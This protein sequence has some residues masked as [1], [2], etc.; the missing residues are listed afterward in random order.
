MRTRLDII[1]RVLLAIVLSG[2]PAPSV[3][4]ATEA[5]QQQEQ[6][7]TA[8]PATPPSQRRTTTHVKINRPAREAAGAPSPTP[9]AQKSHDGE[10]RASASAT[11]TPAAQP[12]HDTAAETEAA[13]KK[14]A[15]EEKEAAAKEAAAR[16]KAEADKKKEADAQAAAEAKRAADAARRTEEERLAGMAALERERAA[17]AS[18]AEAKA[19]AEMEVKVEAERRERAAIEAA[20]RVREEKSAREAAAEK[21]KSDAE[22]AR[23]E[24]IEAAAKE[25]EIILEKE[26]SLTVARLAENEKQQKR[27]SDILA[28]ARTLNFRDP[29]AAVVLVPV[30]AIDYRAP[31][32]DAARRDPSLVR[33]VTVTTGTFCDSEFVGQLITYDLPGTTSTISDILA[34]IRLN[35]GANFIPDTD[36]LETA[37]RLNVTNVPWTVVLRKILKSNDLEASCDAGGIIQIIKRTKLAAMQD[38]ERKSSPLVE[39]FI[40]LRY[41]QISP[42]QISNIAGKSTNPS[43]GAYSTLEEAINK[44]LRGAGDERAQV[45]RVPN[46]NELFV[47]ASNDTL[48]RIKRLIAKA[49]RPSYI[50]SVQALIYTANQNRLKDLGVQSAVTLSN[51]LG[52]T[53]GGFSTL[54]NGGSGSG[55]TSG[56]LNPG[57]IGGIGRG[58]GQPSNAQA[59]IN[60]TVLLGGS[61]LFG[62]AQVAVQL[63]ALQQRGIINIQQRPS[64]L[65]SSGD[66]GVLDVGRNIAVAV[67]ALGT[68]NIATGQLELLNA[69]SSLSI[70]PQV[71]EDENGNPAFVNLDVRLEANDVDTSI[72]TTVAP[73]I[74]RRAI[75]TRFVMGNKQTVL[76][77]AFT[78]DSNT[79]QRSQT[80]V[81]G[82][83]PGIGVLFRRKFEQA[84]QERLYFTISIDIMRQDQLMNVVTPP[85][86]ATTTL[87]PASSTP[88]ALIRK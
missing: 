65:V 56:G 18:A 34:Y 4:A 19:R 20:S 21:A 43:G 37:V 42:Q 82:D 76:F 31:L 23:H 67:Q 10:A 25:R 27:L 5:V 35:T 50:V 3:F 29:A 46:R 16:A 2:L 44:I 73:S 36:I 72:A 62:T 39:E 59:A 79:R 74:N 58:F 63:T 40:P 45:S 6:S 28:L 81:L 88:N 85:V 33:L 1:L 47:A 14:R 41:L 84:A 22:R 70:T 53:L 12:P 66:T 75:Q 64:L 7:T 57:G 83:L 38:S 71:A 24:S 87:L 78:T 49:D 55:G 69:G 17:A 26:K 51:S 48:A 13:N 11:P 15:A 68:G 54:P 30:T 9:P 52:T 61:G 60:P 8:P 80:P 86:D 32:L 77:S